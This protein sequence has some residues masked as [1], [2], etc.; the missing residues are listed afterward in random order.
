M[1]DEAVKEVVG[2]IRDWLNE[3]LGGGNTRIVITDLEEDI[4]D[5]MV[6]K[7]LLEKYLGQSLRMPCGDFVQSKER[8]EA[9]VDYILTVMEQLLGGPLGFTSQRILAGELYP[10]LN[11]LIKLVRHFQNL[12]SLPVPDLPKVVKV[13]LLKMC[14]R[15]GHLHYEKQAINLMGETTEGKRDG[16][17]TLIDHAP[18]KLHFVKESLIKFSNTHLAKLGYPVTDLESD[19]ADGVRLILLMGSLEGYFVPFFT[20]KHQPES[21][22]DRMINVSLAFKLMEEAGLPKP[23]NRPSEVVHGDLRSVLR[24]VYSLFIKYKN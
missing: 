4:K 10:T 7:L 23:R 1:L 18:E 21:T 6:V 11:I 12:G 9:N 3:C 16:F 20:Y 5:G 2:T 13:S 24:V 22:E 14:K 15:N 8:Q 19:F 17:D